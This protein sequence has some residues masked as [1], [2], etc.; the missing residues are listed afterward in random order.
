MAA[1]SNLQ[2]AGRSLA[3]KLSNCK[4]RGVIDKCTGRG[5]ALF[6]CSQQFLN[7]LVMKLRL[8]FYMPNEEIFQ[9]DDLSRQLGLVLK[10]ACHLMEEYKVKLVIRDDVSEIGTLFR[11]EH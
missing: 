6:G 1:P 7:A 3:I 2:S 8:V 11:P 9:K 10:G 5:E 4:Y